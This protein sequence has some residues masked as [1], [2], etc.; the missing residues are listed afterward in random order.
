MGVLLLVP[1]E[2]LYRSLTHMVLIR[3]PGSRI[4]HACL[5]VTVAGGERGGVS[6]LILSTNI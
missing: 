6:S 5:C 1:E 2:Q 3:A 4:Q